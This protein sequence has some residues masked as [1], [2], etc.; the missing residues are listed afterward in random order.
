MLTEVQSMTQLFIINYILFIK[1]KRSF[2]HSPE[3][4]LRAP[5]AGYRDESTGA[6]LGVGSEGNWWSSST[7]VSD[8]SSAYLAGTLWFASTQMRPMDTGYRPRRANALAVRCVQAS[9]RKFFLVPAA[10]TSGRPFAELRSR[11]R[12]LEKGVFLR[13][14]FRRTAVG[15]SLSIIRRKIVDK[16]R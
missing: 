15:E 1:T 5:A 11:C 12:T 6:L 7:F 8:G 13:P 4:L 10:C 16:G 2:R 9:T 14:E 3:R